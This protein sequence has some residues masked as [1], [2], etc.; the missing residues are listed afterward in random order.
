MS[1]MTAA[2]R[3]SLCKLVRDNAKV[4]RADA[5]ARGKW[6]LAQAEAQLAARYKAEAA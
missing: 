3:E 2:E 4:A 5:E 6:L 1:K